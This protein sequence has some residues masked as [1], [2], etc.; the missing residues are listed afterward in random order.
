MA[1]TVALEVV[2]V[3]IHN[4]LF[5]SLS[6]NNIKILKLWAVIVKPLIFEARLRTLTDKM[7]NRLLTQ[8]ANQFVALAELWQK[9]SLGGLSSAISH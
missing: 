2:T 8:V 6:L 9:L 3:L 5:S 4:Y 1:H 7:F